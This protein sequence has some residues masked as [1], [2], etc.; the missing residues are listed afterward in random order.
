MTAD[1]P[2]R[3]PLLTAGVLVGLV[4]LCFSVAA[5]GGLATAD[6]VRE[7]Y[8]SLVRPD[9]RPPNWV[10]G[11]VW[12]VLYTAMAVAMWNV[13][14]VRPWDEI[15]GA[16]TAFGVQLALNAAWSPLFFGAKQLGLA[17]VDIALMWLA[18]AV[19]IGVFWR[20]SRLSAGLLVPY[21]AWVSFA[22][23]LNAWLWWMN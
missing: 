19:C 9:W 7:W 22:S 16:A 21:L 17:L 10:F 18:I 2:D 12:T 6:G 20:H 11:P 5:L 15:R 3:S 8:P 4:G 23:V 13:W 14:R 1:R